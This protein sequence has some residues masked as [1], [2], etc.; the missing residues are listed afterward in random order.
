MER[1]KLGATV[2]C[3]DRLVR[4]HPYVNGH[5]SKIWKRW[6]DCIPG[7]SKPII[8]GTYVGYRVAQDGYSQY[9]EEYTEWHCTG[10]K[11]VWL[12]VTDPRHNP[13]R[14]LPEDTVVIPT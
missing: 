7:G 4:T 2:S 5:Y 9:C 13:I 11:E 6:A 12:V 14:V 1:P 8:S 3:L 10:R